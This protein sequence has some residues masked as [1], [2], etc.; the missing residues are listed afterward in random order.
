MNS[1]DPEHDE[2]PVIAQQARMMEAKHNKQK[3]AKVPR[4]GQKFDS[5][6][7]ER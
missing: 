5:A 3:K 1:T 6:N 7:Y 4:E 2:D